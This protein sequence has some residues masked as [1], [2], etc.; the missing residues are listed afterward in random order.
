[1]T[2]GNRLEQKLRNFSCLTKGD[3]ILIKHINNTYMIDI[4]EVSSASNPNCNAISIVETDVKVDFERPL[5]MPPSPIAMPKEEEFSFKPA[6]SAKKPEPTKQEQPQEAQKTPSFAAF[7]G[8]GRRLDGK[9]PANA[10]VLSSS[11]PTKV[12]PSNPVAKQP[13]SNNAAQS[14]GGIVFGSK[15]AVKP[16]QQETAPAPKQQE[17]NNAKFKAFSGQGRSLK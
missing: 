2:F 3:T 6:P 16:K 7:A 10:S 14:T 5:D 9:G 8:V 11:P 1:L 4:L 12:Q 13:V 15:P 17:D